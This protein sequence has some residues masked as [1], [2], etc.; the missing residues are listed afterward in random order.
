MV[1]LFDP[2]PRV[3]PLEGEAFPRM[4]AG[5]SAHRPSVPGAAQR[6]DAGHGMS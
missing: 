5:G 4:D 3:L 6:I 2:Q 1:H